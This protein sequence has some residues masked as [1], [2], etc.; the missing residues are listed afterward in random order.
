MD[1]DIGKFDVCHQEKEG[2]TLQEHFFCQVHGESNSIER[3][4]ETGFKIEEH[5]EGLKLSW[6]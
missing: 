3:K 5:K 1:A 4:K 2:V 6:W